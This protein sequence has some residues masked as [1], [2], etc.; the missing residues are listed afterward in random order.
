[1]SIFEEAIEL[2]NKINRLE[3]PFFATK[4]FGA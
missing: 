3:K 2:N 1:M 4:I